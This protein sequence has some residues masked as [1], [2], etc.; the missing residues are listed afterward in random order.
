MPNSR[1]SLIIPVLLVA[2]GTGWLLSTL[3][4]G[5]EILWVWTLG[6]GAVGIL[7]FLVGGFDKVTIV[8]GP[9]FLLA[10]GLSYL[11]QSNWLPSNVEVPIL[12]VATGVLMLVAH[13]PAVPVPAWLSL[14]RER[15]ETPAGKKP[16]R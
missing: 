12:L 11:R 4:I 9:I 6:L 7:A 14:P 13:S 15:D 3:G 8:V 2:V 1:S 10:S 5:K 16:L